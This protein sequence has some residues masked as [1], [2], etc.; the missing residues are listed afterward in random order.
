MR[1][2]CRWS[3]LHMVTMSKGR[4]VLLLLL[5]LQT[6]EWWHGVSQCREGRRPRSVQEGS[7]GG[8]GVRER[9]MWPVRCRGPDA[10]AACV[11]GAAGRPGQTARRRRR[12]RRE[13]RG[14]RSLIR[15][16]RTCKK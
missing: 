10:V 15:T 1:Q 4:K 13:K 6:Y 9:W 8:G 11:S 5:L 12:R 7:G 16:I 3:T 14:R 2:I